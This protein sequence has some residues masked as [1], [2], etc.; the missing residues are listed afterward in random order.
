MQK[1]KLL[2]KSYSIFI[3]Y[4]MVLGYL[5]FNIIIRPLIKVNWH[6]TVYTAFLFLSFAFILISNSFYELF[7]KVKEMENKI[8]EMEARTESD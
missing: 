1:L 3:Q 8:K 4:M 5:I 7:T 6:S 2:L